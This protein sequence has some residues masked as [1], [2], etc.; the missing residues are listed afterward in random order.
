MPRTESFSAQPPRRGVPRVLRA[1]GL[2]LALGTT[3]LSAQA[4]PY[5]GVPGRERERERG[6]GPSHRD[7]R[8]GD[9]ERPGHGHP[10]HHAGP[11]H[12]PPP[13]YHAP[14]AGPRHHSGPP[15]HARAHGRRGAGPHHDWY[16]G[17]HV[18]PMYRSRHYVVQDWRVHQLAPPPRGYHWVQN[19]PDYLL[20]T[21]GS[22]V[23]AQIVFR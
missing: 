10:G 15:P 21:V 13:A 8:H 16:Q 19:G 22:G 11:R 17:G 20:V 1:A 7:G 6:H 18:P 2:A 3:F 5:D 14:H 23:I 4:Q 12:A 9:R